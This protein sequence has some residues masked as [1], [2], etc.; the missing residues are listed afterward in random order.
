MRVLVLK[1]RGS[2]KGYRLILEVKKIHVEYTDSNWLKFSD[3]G[4]LVTFVTAF[5]KAYTL[6]LRC[7]F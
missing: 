1:K 5:G 3:L 6:L 7:K 4:C 2:R